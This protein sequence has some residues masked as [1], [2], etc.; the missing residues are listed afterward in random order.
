MILSSIP[1]LTYA[2]AAALISVAAC[3]DSS[4]LENNLTS[5]SNSNSRISATAGTN[6]SGFYGNFV[7]GVPQVTVTDKQGHPLA[8][9][10]VT[11]AAKGGGWLTGSTVLTDSGG[12][13]SPTSWRLGTS[14]AQSV[15]PPVAIFC[16]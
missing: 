3:G 11:F 13:A 12:H 1:K 9:V 4:P 2:L 7:T 14:G 5:S 10:S 8:Q 16:H 6:L 15:Q